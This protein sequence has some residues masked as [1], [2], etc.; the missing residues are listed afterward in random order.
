MNK[1]IYVYIYIY[2]FTHIFIY[3]GYVGYDLI[4]GICQDIINR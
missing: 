2:T 3:V 1:Y 4:Y